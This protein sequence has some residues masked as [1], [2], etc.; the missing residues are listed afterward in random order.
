MIIVDP[1]LGLRCAP[2]QALC[3]R[4]LRRL[5][6]FYSANFRN[7]TG[8]YRNIGV[9]VNVRAPLDLAHNVWLCG[10]NADAGD[11]A[12]DGRNRNLQNDATSQNSRR[13]RGRLDRG[14]G[15]RGLQGTF[16]DEQT[17]S[18]QRQQ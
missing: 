1:Y 10:G 2:P 5:V 14:F 4:L 12:D 16:I 15:Q 7:S 18:H 11:R 17:L 3:C 13:R 9:G 8:S 6:V